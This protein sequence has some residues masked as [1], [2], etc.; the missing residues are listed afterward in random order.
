L[1][2]SELQACQ[3]EQLKKIMTLFFLGQLVGLPTLQ[4]IL[5]KFEI[6]SNGHQ[7][8]Y[9]KLCRNLT[10]NKLRLIFEYIFQHQLKEDLRKLVV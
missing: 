8:K 9:K 7:I 2:E 1:A 6:A 10:N 5:T 3:M 4:S